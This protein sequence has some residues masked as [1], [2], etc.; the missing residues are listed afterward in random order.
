LIILYL[1]FILLDRA[2]E[3][4]GLSHSKRWLR[5]SA[6]WRIFANFYPIK[7]VKEAEL[8]PSKNFI[9]GRLMMFA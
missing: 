8:D 6:F 1:I 7:L 4:G 3:D 5:K 9:F 2:P